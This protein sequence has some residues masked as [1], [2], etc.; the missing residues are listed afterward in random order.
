MTNYNITESEMTNPN[1]IESEMSVVKS[2]LL[3][4]HKK[5]DGALAALDNIKDFGNI[6][7]D[8][9]ART[10]PKQWGKIELGHICYQLSNASKADQY[11]L[12]ADG[13]IIAFVTE[14]KHKKIFNYVFIRSIKMIELIREFIHLKL[15]QTLL[16]N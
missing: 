1:V 5:L 11:D 14:A 10:L 7:E 8:I 15:N 6:E 13:A 4:L 3:N 16:I 2:L 12:K 9:L